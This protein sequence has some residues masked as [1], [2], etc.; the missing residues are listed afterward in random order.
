M[1]ENRADS[2]F[3]RGFFVF[4]NPA[5]VV[6]ERLAGEKL[7]I[8]RGRLV[9]Q[10]EQ[11]FALD[12]HALVI[13]PVVFGRFDA[14]A[15]VDDVG[16]N[17]GFGLLRLIVGDVIVE[18]FEVERIK[19]R[20]FGGNEREA[21]VGAG[22]DADHRNFLQIGAV[23]AGGLQSIERKLRRDVF[24]GNVASTLAGAAPFEKVVGEEANMGLDVIRTNALHSGDGRRGKV[25]AEAGFN[26]RFY[27]LVLRR[28][29]LC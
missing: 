6:S 4:V 13:V 15:D 3:A 19:A 11:D 28:H 18:R 29:F 21:R 26:A 25:R 20:T 22:R 14:I 24:G 17:L 16:V 1:N 12:V 2:P 9:D 7:R 10:H 8:V 27:W 5:A 23:V